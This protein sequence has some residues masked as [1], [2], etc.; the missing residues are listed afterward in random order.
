MQVTYKEIEP[1]LEKVFAASG[2]EIDTGER[3]IWKQVFDTLQTM[4]P[5]PLNMFLR[6]T[7]GDVS[8]YYDEKT[9][10]ENPDYW[11][12]MYSLTTLPW[13]CWLGMEV[14]E[15]TMTNI[16]IAEILG[17]C[18]YEMTWFGPDEETIRKT[19]KERFQSAEGEGDADEA[20]EKTEEVDVRTKCI[21]L[22]KS[23]IPEA[24]SGIAK[25]LDDPKFEQ[26]LREFNQ[27]E[28]RT[29]CQRIDFSGFKLPL[30]GVF[31]CYLYVRGTCMFGVG[32]EIEGSTD[33]VHYGWFA[34]SLKEL[35]PI[36]ESEDCKNEILDVLTKQIEEKK[37][38]V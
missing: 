31:F 15:E 5:K 3:K 7:P 18:I 20:G 19:L 25:Q 37:E 29:Y 12:G 27:E 16:P 8:G 13:R 23:F 24:L 11:P 10:S 34:N 6:V 26:E 30:T 9:L 2:V 4:E 28:N 1:G 21:G 14:D 32:A 36:V 17:A 33:N 35:K 22:M 38:S